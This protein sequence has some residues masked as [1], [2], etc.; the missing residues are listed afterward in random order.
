MQS[1]RDNEKLVD[2][3]LLKQDLSFKR[4]AHLYVDYLKYG[5]SVSST[6]SSWATMVRGKIKNGKLSEVRFD[7]LKTLDLIDPETQTLR[8][9]GSR[10]TLEESRA[11]FNRRVKEYKEYLKRGRL[12]MSQNLSTWVL[13]LSYRIEFG[14]ISSESIEI[15]IKN[16][17]MK[18]GKLLISEEDRVLQRSGGAEEYFELFLV[19]AASISSKLKKN[20]KLDDLDRYWVNSQRS[21]AKN[22]QLEPDRLRVVRSYGYLD[23][24]ES[25]EYLLKPPVLQ[26]EGISRYKLYLSGNSVNEEEY[27]RITKW[28][29]RLDRKLLERGNE[30]IRRKLREENLLT[31]DGKL[32]RP[33]NATETLS[34]WQEMYRSWY[35]LTGRRRI[36]ESTDKAYDGY[37]ELF[38]ANKR[39]LK[40]S[41]TFL[42]QSGFLVLGETDTDLDY[43]KIL[44]GEQRCHLRQ[45][46]KSFVS[47]LS[48][49]LSGDRSKPTLLWLGG[50]VLEINEGVTSLTTNQISVLKEVNVLPRESTNTSL[51]QKRRVSPVALD[52]EGEEYQQRILKVLKTIPVISE[53]AIE[54]K[55]A[56]TSLELDEEIRKFKAYL[57]GIEIDEEERTRLV[58]WRQV[59]NRSIRLES[60][61]GLKNR[62]QDEGLLGS[63]GILLTVSR[64]KEGGIEHW[65]ALFKKW[66]E[67]TGRRAIFNLKE[68]MP[69][70]FAGADELRAA[71]RRAAR[72]VPTYL[73]QVGFLVGVDED[74]DLDYL[75]LAS[76]K[77]KAYLRQYEEIFVKKMRNYLAGDRRREL[78]VWVEDSVNAIKSGNTKMTKRKIRAFI[79]LGF[80]PEGDYQTR[81]LGAK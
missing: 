2:A 20:Q 59:T 4:Q 40:G 24:L 50:K 44:R 33:F 12:G 46:E 55:L 21:R 57:N 28:Q 8:K 76:G 78:M 37:T 13:D 32:V 31:S 19:R 25:K 36:F 52:K 60:R 65:E 34:Y 42:E 54:K 9:K 35:S 14:K 81:R 16:G 3:R 63:D 53:A 49:F 43:F 70:Y 73:E 30:S 1:S 64:Y 38:L 6:A 75:K 5:Y 27:I 26:D 41:K 29:S 66:F 58:L 48:Q 7:F 47:K 61:G 71:N 79:D 74:S 69:G 39:A 72:G 23:G 17:L 10:M 80:L 15:L 62:L 22:G 67:L 51:V 68:G 45:S 18:D 77:Q 56:P 11:N